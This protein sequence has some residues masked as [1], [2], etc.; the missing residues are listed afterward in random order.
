MQGCCWV[1]DEGGVLTSEV[2]PCRLTVAAIGGMT[3]FLVHRREL[4]AFGCPHSLLG[5]GT[6]PNASMAMAAAEAT[7]ARIAAVAGSQPE[8]RK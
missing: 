7:A 6:R 8:V 5:S 2:G 3:R 1:A 4:D